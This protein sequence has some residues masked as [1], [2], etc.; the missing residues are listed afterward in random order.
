MGANA[1]GAH[2]I[3]PPVTDRGGQ[4]CNSRVQTA[5]SPAR[6]VLIATRMRAIDR[7]LRLSQNPT[8]TMA[9]Q[10]AVSHMD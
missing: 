6:V 8:G 5:A 10:N 4:Q 9:N 7:F 1:L 3:E 2:N